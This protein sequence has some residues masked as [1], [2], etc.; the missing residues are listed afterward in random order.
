[1]PTIL[2]VD[3]N[4]AN[5]YVKSRILRA[6]GF[7]VLEAATGTAALDL[8]NQVVPSL[9]LLDIKLPDIS[10]IDVCRKLRAD[11]RTARIPVIHISATHVTAKD[12]A[13]SL[14]AGADIYL[15]EPVDARQL[16]SAVRTL[17]RLRATEQG[18]AAAQTRLRLATEAAGIA[19]WDIDTR[20][21][22]AEWDEEFSRMLGIGTGAAVHSMDEWL[23]SVHE[24]DRES[25]ARA[26]RAVGDNDAHFSQEFRALLPNGEVRWIAAFGRSHKSEADASGRVVGVA[27]D[28]TARKRGELEREAL[29]ASARE[30]QLVAEQA[31]HMKDE[32]LA[33]LSHELRTP[34]S[35]ILGWLHLLKTGRLTSEQER[36]AVESVHS[37]AKVQARLI[38]DLLD[39]SLIVTGKMELEV[40]PVELNDA[41]EAA[42]ESARLAASTKGVEIVA[43]FERGE[44]SMLGNAERVQQIFT[45]LLSNAIKFSPRGKRI[46]VSLKRAEAAVA[47][48]DVVDEGEGIAPE[49]LPHIFERFR[50]ADSSSRR[51][52]GGLGLG[53]AIV[54]SLVE[55]HGGRVEVSSAGPGKGARFCVHLPLVPASGAR[56]AASPE[57]FPALGLEGLRILVVDD[58]ESN[59]QMIANVLR[60]QDASCMAAS[61]HAAALAICERWRPDA[62]I[63]DLGMPEMD[64]YELLPRLR[65]LLD[66]E[67]PAIALTGFAAKQD[68]QRALEA[69]FQAHVAKPADMNQLC[70]LLLKLTSARTAESPR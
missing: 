61:G 55:L 30:A 23:S 14:G 28:V 5:R 41:L 42:V 40:L 47:R 21:G 52:H 20:S 60:L 39:T 26:F 11:G 51:R 53:L 24:C 36:A 18:L 37:S 27:V 50:Q 4:D 25:L 69:G 64:G 38:N 35:A 22:R 56:V 43:A 31:V 48:V 1:M 2:N 58:D 62:L 59:L 63:L 7:E 45:N 19:T 32:F 8:A 67:V 46:E 29:L 66:A 65:A 54:R 9:V 17:L 12:E 44:W 34:M 57:E 15:A 3:D 68:V 10:G 16:S 13:T 49:M 6:A 33:V 70:R